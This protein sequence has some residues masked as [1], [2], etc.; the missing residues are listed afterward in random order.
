MEWIF[1]GIG[2]M[3]IGLL[4]G[5]AAGGAIGWRIGIHSVKQSQRAGDRSHQTQVGRDVGGGRKK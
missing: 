4:V 5:G 2:T 1:D 3:L